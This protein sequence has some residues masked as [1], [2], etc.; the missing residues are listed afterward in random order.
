MAFTYA[1]I[2]V[3]GVPANPGVEFVGTAA[4][5]VIVPDG[6]KDTVPFDPMAVSVCACV[7][8]ADPVNTCVWVASAEPVNVG[9]C[10]TAFATPPVVL[11]SA[12]VASA[13][14]VPAG[15]PAVIEAFVPAGVP[16]VTAEDV[17][18]EPV[19]ACAGTV[20]DAPVKTGTLAGQVIPGAV[21][22]P[23]GV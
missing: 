17:A 22:V 1:G 2:T 6:V 23:V 3:A 16:A 15:V 8:N 10:A 5:H 11:E 20:P 19:N 14:I 18:L 9:V 13:L 21:T 7:A 12:P 4:G